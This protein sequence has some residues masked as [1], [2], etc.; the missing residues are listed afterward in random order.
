MCINQERD[1]Q[2]GLGLCHQSW[3][4]SVFLGKQ[5]WKTFDITCESLC[6]CVVWRCSITLTPKYMHY[7]VGSLPC[8]S[9][10]SWRCCCG[11]HSPCPGKTKGGMFHTSCSS[12]LWS[13]P[14]HL[15]KWSLRPMN[16]GRTQS[17]E[18]WKYSQSDSL[19]NALNVFSSAFNHASSH[20]SVKESLRASHCGHIRLT[21]WWRESPE[22]WLQKFMR[23]N[24]TKFLKLF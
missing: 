19:F 11:E 4:V 17:T 23:L 15:W 3:N 16:F 5:V 6:C 13:P 2:F 20:W 14:S 18:K 22:T 7:V 12:G 1:T 9:G 24:L 10:Q 21:T 8:L